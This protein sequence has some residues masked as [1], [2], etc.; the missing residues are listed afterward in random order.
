MINIDIIL[1]L[2]EIEIYIKSRNLLSQYK[3]AKSKIL[4]WDLKSVLFKKREPKTLNVYQF[5]INDK[6]RA[7]WFFDKNNSK[8]FKIIEISDHQD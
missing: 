7:F 1:E 5:R 8:I 2:D 3:K 6:Y 4:S